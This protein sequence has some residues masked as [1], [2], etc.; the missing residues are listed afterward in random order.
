[1]EA[2]HLLSRVL[3][4]Y[5]NNY[6]TTYKSTQKTEFG[7]RENAKEKRTIVI[8]YQ[9]EIP[10]IKIAQYFKISSPAVSTMVTEGENIVNNNTTIN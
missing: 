8:G 9:Y 4:S 1:M 6:F 10:V 7:I 3:L 2:P 5:G